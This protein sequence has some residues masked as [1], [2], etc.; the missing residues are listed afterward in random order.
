V[1]LLTTG[2]A[3]GPER[4][5][6]EGMLAASRARGVNLLA[7]QGRRLNSPIL[8]DRNA[9]LVYDLVDRRCCD[10]L[11]V[12]SGAL[13]EHVSVEQLRDFCLGFALPVVTIGGHVL[14]GIPSI[15][16]DF[17]SGMRS[18]VRHLVDVHAF[19][20]IAFI[21]GLEGQDE[22]EQRFRAYRD[23]VAERGLESDD[24]LVV[25][26]DFQRD[27]GRR[28]VS[29]L[30][31]ERGKRPD[32]I[33]AVNDETALGALEE[34]AARGINVPGQMALTGFDDD[35]AVRWT[36]P[37][38][39]TVR[40]SIDA[41]AESALDILLSQSSETSQARERLSLEPKIRGSC[42]CQP[43]TASESTVRGGQDWRERIRRAFVTDVSDDTRSSLALWRGILDE[44][45]LR[46]AD[47][48]EPARDDSLIVSQLE[49]TAWHDA[50]ESAYLSV[51]S[52]RSLNAAR[53]NRADEL[54]WR[55]SRM[56]ADA[57]Q[58]QPTYRGWLREQHIWQVEEIGQKLL[59]SF[60]LTTM[61]RAAAD[62]LPA[63]GIDRF[64]IAL[65]EKGKAPSEQSR[66]LIGFDGARSWPREGESDT[67]ESRTLAPRGF[68]SDERRFTFVV[69]PLVFEDHQ[70]GFVLFE[71]E[72]EAQGALIVA[73]RKQLSAALQGAMLVGQLEQRA[74][75]L[76]QAH[77]IQEEQRQRL[78]VVERMAWLGRLTA[79]VAHE[80]NTPVAAVRSSLSHLSDLIEEYRTSIGDASVVAHD[81][82]ELA[83]E[84]AD[85]VT[86]AARAAQNVAKFV[87]EFKER[88]RDLAPKDR[89]LFNAVPV[90]GEA[91]GLLKNVLDA[92]DSRVRFE[93]AGEVVNVTG[94]QE[95]LAQVLTNLVVNAIDAQQS[96]GGGLITIDLGPNDDLV[97]L[98]VADDG[99]GIRDDVL[100]RIFEPMFSTRSYGQ[101]IGLGLSIAR[102]IV[103]S[104]FGGTIKIETRVGFGTKVIVRL[105][106]GD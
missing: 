54:G 95:R 105:P 83:G 37:P 67:F 42:G 22:A 70:L 25:P 74:R 39:S 100:P 89:V 3:Y 11:V 78:V 17:Y 60:D 5:L 20:R 43:E 14:E 2:F 84:M 81:H 69:E 15:V 16:F 96:K 34:L 82:R 7:F 97:I 24:G 8:A 94:S 65:Y 21:R 56:I 13:G 86:L 9:N 104:E 48:A 31:D 52:E 58:R 61:A 6:F 98:E 77:R 30:L 38:L 12:W 79:G 91:L 103:E 64:A 47:E 33:V 85:A 26:G 51:V 35:D 55:I 19:R 62:A 28:A 10:G 57:G 73:L 92:S 102:D 44:T 68:F 53:R 93:P 101:H 46:P 90:V 29:I 71:A 36:N 4:R 63:A 45:L 32:A 49:A 40:F 1:G 59:A 50:L 87:A 99:E 27:A 41:A 18:L 75:E 80:M 106:R 23:V 76:E 66:L 88:T 72:S